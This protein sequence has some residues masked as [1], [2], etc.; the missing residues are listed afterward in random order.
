MYLLYLWKIFSTWSL[1]L[2][3]TKDGR[4]W[5]ENYECLGRNCAI[6]DR[7]FSPSKEHDRSTWKAIECS[8]D[9]PQASWMQPST[10]S[11]ESNA[12][13]SRSVALNNRNAT[14]R[15]ENERVHTRSK[16]SSRRRGEYHTIQ[17]QNVKSIELA[18][19][20]LIIEFYSRGL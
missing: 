4:A 17:P 10:P 12:T 15:G 20:L 3:Q 7:D 16:I 18:S 6:V 8:C 14:H 9:C 19:R 1:Q 13:R 11:P 2:S 5:L